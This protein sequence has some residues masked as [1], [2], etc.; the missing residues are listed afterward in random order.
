M[1]YPKAWKA[2]SKTYCASSREKGKPRKYMIVVYVNR[3]G[4]PDHTR[5]IVAEMGYTDLER[6]YKE[7]EAQLGKRDDETLGGMYAA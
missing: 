5:R 1:K 3:P 4:T 7:I 6:L 2:D